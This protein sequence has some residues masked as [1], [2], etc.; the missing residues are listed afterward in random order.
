MNER[1]QLEQAIAAIERERSLLG[2]EVAAVAISALREKLDGL[3]RNLKPTQIAQQRKQVTVLFADVSGFTAMSETMDHEEVSTVINSLWS[4]VDGA[5]ISQGGRIDKHIGDAVMALFGAPTS[6]EDDPERAVRA[7]LRV[8]SAIE[9]WKQEF[10][11]SGS[12]IRSQILGLRLRLG[13]NTGPALIGTIGSTGEYTAIGDTV[14]LASRM[15]SAAPAGGILI[16]HNTYRHVLGIFDASALEPVR[17][18]GKSEPVQVYLIKGIKPPSMRGSTRGVEGIRTRMIGREAELAKLKSAFE[19]TAGGTKTQLASVV[20]EAGTG[21]SRLISEF[22][23]WLEQ[24]TQPVRV[25]KGRATADMARL[26]ASLVRDILSTAFE[27]QESD[28]AAVAREKLELGIQALAPSHAEEQAAAHFIGQLIGFDFSASPHLSGILGDARQLRDL[29]FHYLAEVFGEASAQQTVV[30]LL[31]G[32]QWADGTSL[33]LVDYLLRA[34]P[35]RRLFIICNM[36][37]ALF[38]TR[39]EWGVETEQRLRVDLH[40]LTKEQCRELVAE[41]LQKLP[42]IPSAIT[43]LIVDKAEGSPF[44]IEEL[45]NVLI[46]GGVI[47]TDESSWRVELDKLRTLKVPATLTGLLQAR[48][49]TLM[50]QDREILQQASVVGRVFWPSVLERMSNPD[51]RQA[52]VRYALGESLSALKIKE[53]IFENDASSFADTSEYLFKNAVL[54]DVTYESVL[55]RLRRVYHLQVAE[56]LIRLGGERVAEYAGRVGEHYERAG[57]WLQAAEWYTQAG[58][59]A[60]ETYSPEPAAAYFEKALKFYREIRSPNGGAAQ[61]EIRRRFGEVLEWQAR[62]VEAIENYRSML[63]VAVEEGDRVAQAWALLGTASCLG[64]QGDQRACMEQAVKAEHLAREIHAQPEIAKALWTEGSAFF[65]LG[66]GQEALTRAEEA[67]AISTELNNRNQMAR[68]MNLLGAA[69]YSLGRYGQAESHMERALSLFQGLGDRR[70][71]MD[72]LNNLGVIAD[73]RGDYNAAFLRY[74]NALELARELGYRDGEIVFLTNRGGV[75]VALGNYAAAEL[76]LCQAVE[77]AGKDGSWILPKTQYYL[78]EASLRLG[79]MGQ[80]LESAKVSLA[81]GRADGAPEYIGAA[82]RALGMVAKELGTSI[83]ISNGDGDKDDEC[84]GEGFFQESLRILS[85]ENMDY[86][87]A[88]TLREWARYDLR[89]GNRERGS[90]MWEQSREIFGQL[91]AQMEVERMAQLPS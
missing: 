21:K 17:V 9:A 74:H 31:E 39:P 45:I 75:Q 82:Y 59:R 61:L 24:Q 43:D 10:V 89:E 64:Q 28:R 49:D 88:L 76:D 53:M 54:H 65:R 32:M 86:E 6:R 36:R 12:P 34:M 19:A 41:I 73:A 3:E 40:P 56:G 78:C 1:E 30:L 87:R 2:E 51:N 29:A 15:E 69:C 16:S 14:N 37:A 71:G 91:G 47:I 72:L 77:L 60:Q 25:F 20:A 42:E 13:I 52:E 44:Y 83:P 48:L 27:I 90:K 18:K 35:N 67:L 7:A 11:D 80:A 66:E 33:D 58:K 79:N 68:C 8:Q 50:P 5:I 57:E 62:Y 38:E 4:R 55:L 23:E 22:L 85:E 84:D 46:E 63:E 81:L 70:Q 26:P